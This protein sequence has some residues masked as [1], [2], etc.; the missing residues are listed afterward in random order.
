M[1]LAGD[2]TIPQ[3]SGFRTEVEPIVEDLAVTDS[4]E[5]VAQGA[6]FAVEGETF[7]VDVGGAEAGEARGFVLDDIAA[8]VMCH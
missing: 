3:I 8:S 5:L 4:D 1:T 2:D 6:D 7:E